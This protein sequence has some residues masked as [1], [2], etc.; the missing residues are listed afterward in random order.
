MSE[1]DT[2]ANAENKLS[3]KASTVKM[4]QRLKGWLEVIFEH[5]REP[6]VTPDEAMQ[7]LDE[8]LRSWISG[9]AGSEKSPSATSR[10]PLR[11]DTVSFTRRIHHYA[12]DLYYDTY[13]PRWPGTEGKS[14]RGAPPLSDEYLEQVFRLAQRG[15][16]PKEIA[17]KLGQLD[18]K[19]P[20]RIRKQIDRY[21]QRRSELE[22]N[23]RKIGDEQRRRN[24]EV[25]RPESTH[26]N[27]KAESAP[28]AI[29]KPK[30][31]RTR[32]KE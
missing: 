25:R 16:H 28:A 29:T 32:R 13:F 18:P 20:D 2:L 31:K 22:K 19:A 10:L 30:A 17:D 14:S 7:I 27:S 4:E 5:R 6:S 1:N 12:V 11:I 9:S 15:K 23:I 3:A 24:A 21:V 8:M 26:A